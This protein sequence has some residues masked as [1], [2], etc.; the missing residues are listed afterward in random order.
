MDAATANAASGADDGLTIGRVA[1][2]VGV[3]VRTLHH[4][5]EIGLVS[6]ATRTWADYR[7]Y[8]AADIERIQQVLLYRELGLSLSD[9]QAVLDDPDADV[10]AQLDRQ[11]AVLS[12]RLDRLR[13][14]IAAVDRMK[15]A[16]MSEQKLTPE[17][18]AEILGDGWDP[19]WQDE[20][21][22]NWGDTPEWA[23]SEKIKARM[24][25]DDWKRVKEE[26]DRLEADLAAA[27]TAGV[28]PGSEEANALAQR[29]RASIGQWF[30]ITVQKQVC[31]AR[32]YVQDPRFTAHYDERAQGLAAW[33]T[34]IIDA[35]ARA[36][37][38]DPATAVWE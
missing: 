4:W 13:R 12:E 17:Q 31:I 11:R 5:D 1:E 30:D 22:E 32:M 9:V 36:Q 23:Q 3:S 26:T 14:M 25:V 29:H 34:A 33:L 37:G 27:M 15:E 2:L 20:A 8:R 7:V 10:L 24:G 18:Q 38:I 21:Q 19:A 6:P 16:H 35:H 28:Q